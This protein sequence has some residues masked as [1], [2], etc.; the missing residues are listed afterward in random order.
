MSAGLISSRT[1]KRHLGHVTRVA[2]ERERFFMGL[3]DSCEQPCS[4][5]AIGAPKDEEWRWL[6]VNGA[7]QG[8]FKQPLEFFLDKPCYNWGANICKTE[9][10]GRACHAAGRGDTRFEQDFGGG[11]AH[12]RVYTQTITDL[13]GQ[14]AYAI[15]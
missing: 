14:P 13:E 3:L 12:F 11:L 8:A 9:D 7:V 10:C 6:Y 5:T 1:I 2:A 15:E 4:V